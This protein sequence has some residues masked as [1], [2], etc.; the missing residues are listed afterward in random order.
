MRTQPWTV[1][2]ALWE[3]V[4]PLILPAPSHAR[5]GR[6][7]MDDRQAFTAIVSALWTGIQCGKADRPAAPRNLPSRGLRRPGGGEP[8]HRHGWSAATSRFSRFTS[9]ILCTTSI[10]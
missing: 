5:G 10:S 7:R 2:D 1:S 8:H 3:R 6:T 4:V 9:R